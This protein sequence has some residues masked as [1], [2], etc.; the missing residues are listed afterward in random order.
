MTIGLSREM[1]RR[2][3]L[4]AVTSEGMGVALAV[5]FAAAALVAA[6]GSDAP[7]VV[8]TAVAAGGAATDRLEWATSSDMAVVYG[9]LCLMCLMCLQ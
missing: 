2:N 3:A 7:V 8:A 1:E 5:P 6:A 4:R 9:G